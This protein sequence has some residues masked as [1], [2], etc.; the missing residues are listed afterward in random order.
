MYRYFTQVFLAQV[1]LVSPQHIPVEFYDRIY[2]TMQAFLSSTSYETIRDG[3]I[4]QWYVWSTFIPYIKLLYIPHCPIP[5]DG[6]MRKLQLLS[7]EMILFGLMNML[8]R[9]NHRAV[10]V[11]EGLVDY[12]I[13]CPNYVPETLKDNAQKLVH[14]VTSS[15]DIRRQPA[16]LTNMVKAGLAKVHFGLEQI[17]S[18]SVGAIVNDLLPRYPNT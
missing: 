5:S 6:M 13:C 15:F 17:L 10:L 4:K 16:R 18:L 12:I 8:S 7:V 11:K 2:D 14:L 1:I 3:E 9:E